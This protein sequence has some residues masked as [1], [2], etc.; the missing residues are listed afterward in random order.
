MLAHEFAQ[1]ARTAAPVPAA[2]Q[3]RGPSSRRRRIHDRIPPGAAVR[4]G[5]GSSTP[6]PANVPELAALLA[7]ISRAMAISPPAPTADGKDNTSVGLFWWRKR[8]FSSCNSRAEVM[9]TLSSPSSPMARRAL[10]VNLFSSRWLILSDVRSI[11]LTSFKN[12]WEG[13]CALPF[14]GNKLLLGNAIWEPGIHHRRH[15]DQ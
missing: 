4:G 7:A 8:R 10:A 6:S 3:T 15:L 11:S 12:K 14:H 2:V 5:S 1:S 13:D 9:R